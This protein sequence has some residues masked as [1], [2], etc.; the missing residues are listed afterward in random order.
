MAGGGA[1]GGGVTQ[2]LLG[3]NPSD[4][5][6]RRW[7]ADVQVTRETSPTFLVHTAEDNVAVVEN[8]LLFYQAMRGAGAPIEM[9]LYAKDPH[10]SGMDPKLGLVSEWPSQC[11]SWLRANGWLPQK[12]ER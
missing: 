1:Y 2:W 7:S 10:G 4:E 11:E 5:L 12:T 3:E 6:K 9:H 8:S